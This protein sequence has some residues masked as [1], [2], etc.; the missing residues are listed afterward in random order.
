VSFKNSYE[1]F[2][3]NIDRANTN[4]EN[5]E[6]FKKIINK[7]FEDNVYSECGYEIN[8][9]GDIDSVIKYNGDILAL[10]EIKRPKNINEMVHENDL[11]RKALHELIFYFLQ[12]T[13]NTAEQKVKRILSEIRRL[14]IS[15][16]Y[17][18]YIFDAHD[19]EKLCDGYLEIQYYKYE[20]N[21]LSYGKNRQKF[22]DA[23][24]HH[25]SDVN[26]NDK[27]DYVFFDITSA[28]ASDVYKIL[29]KEY[30]LKEKPSHP[31]TIL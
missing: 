8:T 6:Y 19:I 29:S 30:L 13:R 24:S 15:N 20:N 27:L 9:K 22:Y 28:D 11:D 16:G 2:I 26:V 23:I 31:H 7:F 4:D 14:V 25:L 3:A 18:W 17:R 12:L 10:F 5:E 1:H 21:Q